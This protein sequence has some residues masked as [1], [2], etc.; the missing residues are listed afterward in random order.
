[1]QRVLDAV[2]RSG[3]HNRGNAPRVDTSNVERPN[4]GA[5]TSDAT[6]ELTSAK[7]VVLDTGGEQ[8][9]STSA[10]MRGW[11]AEAE[12]TTVMCRRMTREPSN[13]EGAPVEAPTRSPTPSFVDLLHEIDA[14]SG[15]FDTSAYGESTLPFDSEFDGFENVGTRPTVT[16]PI[17]TTIQSVAAKFR[18]ISQV[19]VRGVRKRR[20][21]TCICHRP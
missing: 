12:P 11:A 15:Q 13:H 7:Q 10:A 20:K 1:M 9:Q 4:D 19:V 16:E 8:N 2:R 6:N 17:G 5:S 18:G 14:M 3:R 21:P